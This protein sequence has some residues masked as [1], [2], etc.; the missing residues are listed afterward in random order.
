[1]PSCYKHYETVFH[2]GADMNH[3]PFDG[4]TEFLAVAEHKSFT[5]AATRLAV[6]P[7][8]VSHAIKL[9]ERRT[10]VLLFQR[11]TRRVALTEAGASLFA[12]LRPAA[13]EIDEALAVLSGFR[14]Q[15]MGTLRITAPRLSGA[16]L[17]EPLMP[18]FRQAYPQVGL[19]IS[20]DD[21]TV[22]L[23]ESGFD[24]GIRLGESIEKDMIAVRLTPDLQWSVVG[25]PAYFAKA[26]K[27]LSPEELTRHACIGFRFASSGSAHRWEFR[28]DGRD[29]TV[30][31]ESGVL[32]N[33]RKLL[34]SAARNGLGL[35]Y[36]CNLE[37]IDELA[38]GQLERVLQ[39]FVPLSSG[40]YLYF[41]SRTQTQPK[42]RAFIDMAT[43]WI[44]DRGGLGH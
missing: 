21:A 34:I 3:D 20:L 10:G 40:L 4:L 42:L 29:F 6:T 37:I 38:N 13:S 19:D 36:A 28:R 26:G 16:L 5:L 31:V 43:Q 14:D 1:M 17:I 41:P 15:P 32:V 9:L 8:A 25:S 7:T 23:M 24:A 2:N 11:T 35:A 30:G 33:D 27:P 18:L 44:A 39:P 22:D 12:R